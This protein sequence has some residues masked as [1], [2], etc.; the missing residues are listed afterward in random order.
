MQKTA[1]E[2]VYPANQQEWRQWLEKNHALKQAVWVVMYKKMANKPS[3]SWSDA[4]DEALC[5]GWI[6]SVKRSVDSESS[7]QFFSKRKPKSGWSKI[8][9]AKVDRLI[10]AGLMTGAGLACIET[11]KQNGSWTL[12]D[13]VEEMTMPR[14]LAEALKR[15]PGAEPYFLSL[16]RSVRKAM[17]QW[18]VLAKRP[19]T[20][21]NRINEISQLAAQQQKPKQ[22]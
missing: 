8:N 1:T 12:L 14:D 20:R 5:F 10:E 3:I 13:E 21:Q 11:A 2:T 19:E 15:Q 4:V 17:L 22:F 18:L 9:K 16:S 6:D 7:V